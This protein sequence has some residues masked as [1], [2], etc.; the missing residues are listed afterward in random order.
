MK[1]FKVSVIV[2]AYNEAENVIPLTNRLVPLL[3]KYNDYEIIF[4][5]DGSED[6]TLEVIECL[7]KKNSKIHFISFSK[8]FGH[9][10]ALRAGIDY[11]SGNCIISMDADMQ[12]PP[13]LIPQ[14]IEEWQKGY[15]VVYTIRQDTYGETIFKKITSRLFYK[16]FSF[17]SGL[18]LPK[19]TADFRLLDKK[20]V[21]VIRNLSER[22]LFLRGMVFWMG[23]NQKAILYKADK[24]FAGK[25]S[26][27]LRKMVG[28]AVLG[29]TSFS[30]KPLRMA[31][32]LGLLIAL[33]GGVFTAYVLYMR[34]FNGAVITG[35]ASIMSVILILGGVQLFIMGIIG[36][37]IGMI[38][39]ETKKRPFYIV[40]ETTL[41]KKE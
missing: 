11:A 6:T 34:L 41:T 5:N 3:E 17:F 9:Q 27:T 7:H 29:A 24:R 16:V 15:D 20:A 18:N 36:E 31:V 2:P 21:E 19:G 1:N 8:N 32:Y 25:S 4:I 37:Y 14:M 40:S 26:Y 12:H 38:F 39:M 35:W 23:F 22:N 33:L 13:E 10:Y 28:L 30:V